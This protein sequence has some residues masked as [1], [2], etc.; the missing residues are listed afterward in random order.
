MKLAIF[1]CHTNELENG[2]L[3]RYLITNTTI[4]LKNRLIFQFTVVVTKHK[5][6][7]N[8]RWADFDTKVNQS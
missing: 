6:L 1:Q 2:R 3:K 4:Y 8:V 7:K 5:L